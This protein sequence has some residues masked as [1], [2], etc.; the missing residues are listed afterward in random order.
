MIYA[1]ITM[2][3]FSWPRVNKIHREFRSSAQIT[4]PIPEEDM[5]SISATPVEPFISL[6]NV[7]YQYPSGHEA[8][9]RDV[10]LTIRRNTTA[11]F[12]GQ[13]GAGKSTLVDIIVGLLRPLERFAPSKQNL[14]RR[15]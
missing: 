4:R 6:Q 14:C 3:K 12:Y 11:G 7:V 5:T 8:A 15:I 9:T 10:S 13:T 2:I 1:D